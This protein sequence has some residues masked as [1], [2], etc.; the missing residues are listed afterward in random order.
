M[1]SCPFSTWVGNMTRTIGSTENKG[2]GE[3]K[4]IEVTNLVV[5]RFSGF[6]R[7]HFGSVA[8]SVLLTCIP[9][10]EYINFINSHSP[11]ISH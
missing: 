8:D 11:C 1:L 5:L 9:S 6:C 10:Q 2:K 3:L 4:M 7:S